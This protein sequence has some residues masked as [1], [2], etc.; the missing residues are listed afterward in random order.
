M[1]ELRPPLQGQQGQSLLREQVQTKSASGRCAQNDKIPKSATHL[2]CLIWFGA[3]RPGS[4]Q[5]A[6]ALRIKKRW[7]DIADEWEAPESERDKTDGTVDAGSTKSRGA[8]AF[9]K[10]RTKSR[11]SESV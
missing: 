3:G 11:P 10:K 2:A 8:E 6:G 9:T 7:A 1:S 4:S 5:L